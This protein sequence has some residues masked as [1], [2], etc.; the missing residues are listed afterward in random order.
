VQSESNILNQ[1]LDRLFAAIVRGPSIDCKPTNSRQRLDLIELE[2]L[3]DINPIG[4]V[5]ELMSEDGEVRLRGQVSRPPP[6][7]TNAPQVRFGTQEE[8]ERELSPEE[9]AAKKAWQR[10]SKVVRKL[11]NIAEEART[12]EED[13]GVYVLNVGFPLLHLPKHTNDGGPRV[14]AP[15]AFIPVQLTVSNGAKPVIE[16]ACR[17]TGE[18]RLVPNESLFAWI[19]RQTGKSAEELFTD[20]EGVDPWRELLDITKYVCQALELDLPSWANP[21]EAGSENSQDEATD[22]S[23]WVARAIEE[24]FCRAPTRDDDTSVR[25][26][27]AAA[28]LG[29]FPMSNQ[30]LLRDTQEMTT[31]DSFED[32]LKSFLSVDTEMNQDE[33]ESSKVA[34]L[35]RRVFQDERF[36]QL[37]DP[38]QSR[39]IRLA[40][41]VN[42]LVVHGPPGTGKSQTIANIIGDHLSRDQRV[43]FVC[44]KRTALDVVAQRLN[45]IGL[46]DLCALIHDTKRDQRDLYMNVRSQLESLSETFHRPRVEKQIAKINT[47]LQ[48]L[49]D[50]LLKTWRALMLDHDEEADQGIPDPER[51]GGEGSFHDL[52]GRWLAIDSAVEIPEAF[53]DGIT[54]Q[55]LSQSELEIDSILQRGVDIDYPSNPWVAAAGIKLSKF[56]NAPMDDLRFQLDGCFQSAQDADATCV[57]GLHPFDQDQSFD[58]QAAARKEYA[59]ELDSMLKEVPVEWR[60]KWVNDGDAERESAHLQLTSMV[61][62]REILDGFRPDPEIDAVIHSESHTVPALAREIAAI[63]EYRKVSAKWWGF[64]AFGSKRK[65]KPIVQRYGMALSQENAERIERA[66]VIKRAQ[67]IL[68]TSLEQMLGPIGDHRPSALTE[69]FTYQLRVLDVLCRWHDLGLGADSDSLSGAVL[70]QVSPDILLNQLLAAEPRSETIS[71]LLRSMRETQLFSE[72]WM[73]SFT[74]RLANHELIANDIARFRDHFE[75]LESRLRIREG[76]AELPAEISGATQQLLERGASPERGLASLER[77]MLGVVIRGLLKNSRLLSNLDGKRVESMFAR[78][79]DLQ[80]EKMELV[81]ESIAS[82]WVERQ[83][84]RLLV[85]TGSRLNSLGAKIKQRLLTRGKRSMRIRQVI[86]HGQGIEGGDPLFDLKPVWMASPDTV[87]QIFPR[88]PIFDVV[89][90]D[91]AS[92]CRL[93]EALPVLTRAKRVVIAGDPKQLPPTRFFE[94]AIVGSE[95]REIETDQ[96]LFE[97]QQSEVE[98]LLGA[99]LNLELEHAYLNVHYRSKNADLIEFSNEQFYGS[100]LQAIPGHPS[101]F[102]RFAPLQ[103]THAG[104]VYNDGTNPIEAQRVVQVVQDLLKR[105][106]PPSIGIASFNVAQRDLIL[107]TLE[108]AAEQDAD[109]ARK[110]SVARSRRGDGSFEGLFVKNLENVQGDERDH[111]IISTTYGPNEEGRFYRRFGPLIQAGGGRRL[112]VLVTRARHEVHIVTSIPADQYRA[113]PPIPEGQA[114]GGAWLLFAYLHYAEHLGRLYEEAHEERAQA[115]SSGSGVVRTHQTGSPSLVAESLAGTLANSG[116]GSEVYWGNEGFCIDIALDHPSRA[117]D[118]TVGVQLDMNRFRGATDPIEWELYREG[119]LRWQ[120]W[121][122]HRT[123]SPTMFRDLTSAKAQIGQSID[124]FLE[125]DE[126]PQSIRTWTN[127]ES[128]EPTPP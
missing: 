52:V 59:Q 121:T 128:D 37:A 19:E 44:D 80:S 119:I 92:Q 54:D 50:E 43:L 107:D 100:R 112:N 39:A 29:L 116:Q 64:L 125:S 67:I 4:I 30:S 1:M 23:E 41:Q 55:A 53:A 35:H 89:I 94:S 98:D 81:R 88:E 96:D 60:R 126:D 48:S 86:R 68:G 49:H 32:P 90:F 34:H 51:G 22:P 91:E 118:V 87:A 18:D 71:G 20:E 45:H 105:A 84:E 7:H 15:L 13:T 57:L 6:K 66:L 72:A 3:R 28:V 109:F 33:S 11:R 117:D 76:L 47:Q 101:H 31:A 113:L 85:G 127:T 36:V 78:M 120:G 12:Y 122:L 56:L 16:L 111:I 21:E 104:G 9:R 74:Q 114:P 70:G 14:L 38:Y 93:E 24:E 69:L 46:G 42:G 26:L 124:A 63:G 62:M 108:E 65:A 40:R 110:L 102:T 75:T 99:A 27:R 83:R 61:G 17:Y 5:H 95:L 82:R 106:D 73:H 8:D 115:R 25:E 2:A 58:V 77:A 103:L 10:Q 123:W 79:S 97:V